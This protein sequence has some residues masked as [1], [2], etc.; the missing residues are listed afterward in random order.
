LLQ[1]VIATSR[2]VGV[3]ALRTASGSTKPPSTIGSR[4]SVMKPWS[5]SVCSGRETLLCSSVLVMA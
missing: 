2:V 1:C 3:I 4:V 5:A